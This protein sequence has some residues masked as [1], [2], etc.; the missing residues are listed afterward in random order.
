[1]AWN[2]LVHLDLQAVTMHVSVIVSKQMEQSSPIYGLTP[3]AETFGFSVWHGLRNASLC[4][5]F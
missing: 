5:F 2:D 1:L 3:G 4:S